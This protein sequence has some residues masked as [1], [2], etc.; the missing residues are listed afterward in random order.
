MGTLAYLTIMPI[1]IF[2]SVTSPAPDASFVPEEEIYKTENTSKR[3]TI[4]MAK[5]KTDISNNIYIPK[6]IHHSLYWPELMKM[7]ASILSILLL[8][9]RGHLMI[10]R[11]AGKQALMI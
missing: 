6:K 9:F 3:N 2:T 7:A 5:T 1:D 11:E 8:F 4:F 10:L